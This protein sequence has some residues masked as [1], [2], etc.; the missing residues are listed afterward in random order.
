MSRRYRSQ[1]AP[2]PPKDWSQTTQERLAL[3]RHF[4]LGPRLQ[5]ALGQLLADKDEL[6]Q[7]GWVRVRDNVYE[8]DVPRDALPTGVKSMRLSLNM[9][10]GQL[11]RHVV[12]LADAAREETMRSTN[13]VVQ[14]EMALVRFGAL[15]VALEERLGE[16]A[17][18]RQRS[19]VHSFTIK[20]KAT[21]KVRLEV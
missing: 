12:G 8:R 5:V 21:E 17:T 2:P 4:G 9:S 6:A 7:L 18:V 15:R 20:T 14:R 16:R 10:E 11:S 1:M 13:P 3:D 19:R